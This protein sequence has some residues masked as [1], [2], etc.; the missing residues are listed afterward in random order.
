MKNRQPPLFRKSG[1]FPSSKGIPSVLDKKE[2][3][4]VVQ[5]FNRFQNSFIFF[6]FLLRI[7]PFQIVL[8]VNQTKFDDLNNK[9]E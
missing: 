2:G 7:F 5:T 4:F 1:T 8:L 6:H 3:K 9:K